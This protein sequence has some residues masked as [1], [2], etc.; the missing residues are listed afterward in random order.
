MGRQKYLN[1]EQR[2][3]VRLDT[4]FP[5]QIRLVSLEGN[6]LL[7][8]WL[9]GFTNNVSRGGLCLSIGN[10][11]ENFAEI[12]KSRQALISLEM[13]LPF[14]PKPVTARARIAWV[15]NSGGI[16]DKYLIGLC[17]ED[18]DKKYV[19][20][21]MRYAWGRKILIPLG[22]GLVVIFSL[23]LGVNGLINLR[24]TQA[25]KELVRKLVSV[26]R[27]ASVAKEEIARIQGEAKGLHKNIENLIAQ[28]NSAEEEK[29]RL[30]EKEKVSSQEYLNKLDSLNNLIQKLSE[31]KNALEEALSFALARESVVKEEL[32]RLDRIKLTLEKANVD[33]MYRWV[34]VHQNARTGL[35]ISFEGDSDIK[36]WSFIYDQSLAAQAYMHYSDL[37]AAR[38]ILDFFLYQAKKEEGLFFNAYYA[39]DGEVSEYILH[40]GPN[41]WIGIAAAQYI[42]RTSDLKY[43]PLAE[44]IAN[45]IIQLQK[46]DREGGLRG[47]PHVTWYSTEHNLDAYAFLN[48]LYEITGKKKYADFRDLVLN[49]LIRHAYDK[50]DVPIKRGRG[51]STIATDT[52]AWS[53]A[54]IGPD[55]LEALGMDPDGIMDFAVS[56]CAVEVEYLRPEGN[57]VKVKGFDFAPRRHVARGGV[58]SAEWTAQMA[59]SFKIMENFYSKRGELK[60][61]GEYRAQA[62]EYLSCLGNMI[63]S[64]PSP[65]G[66]GE[67][68][69]PYATSE[70]VDTGHGWF[71]PKGRSTGSLA[72]TTYAIFAY[73]NYNPL[74]F[75]D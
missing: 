62:K 68:C 20:K 50:V 18:M 1:N 14:I 73:Y 31:E 67:S 74:A 35:V 72:G 75:K 2:E 60:R 56:N 38:K 23:L 58:V 5:V 21:I 29:I 53:I 61:A 39:L 70:F 52:Y 69:L 64:S 16:K 24:L 8:G 4:V 42:R 37:E 33:K 51:D 11:G 22:I 9:Q 63:I 26:I 57:R 47:G 43:L 45:A 48:M 6:Q 46:Q 40:S 66:Q 19:N 13:E 55:K 28:I 27:E 17:Y 41:I 49:W 54:A 44:G 65:S 32:L 59:I 25:N 12:I 36:G 7:S 34:R 15:Q 3:Y 30:S 10:L 71:T